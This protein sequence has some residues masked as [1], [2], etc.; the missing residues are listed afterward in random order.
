MKKIAIAILVLFSSGSF[1]NGQFGTMVSGHFEKTFICDEVLLD[2]DSDGKFSK[3]EYHETE[4]VVSIVYDSFKNGRTQMTVDF[5][6]YGT[7]GNT[8]E[9][10][11]ALSGIRLL[12]SSAGIVDC[13]G[14]FDSDGEESLFSLEKDPAEKNWRLFVREIALLMDNLDYEEY[15]MVKPFLS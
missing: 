4:S 12:D 15:K 10:H 13:F 7:N 8:I 11:K 9:S 2:M 14:V 6:L 3:D 5:F 1:S